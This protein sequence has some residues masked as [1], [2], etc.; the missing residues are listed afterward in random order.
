MS[1]NKGRRNIS[2][3]T[4]ARLSIY[5]RTLTELQ[6]AGTV[7]LYSHDLAKM[8]GGTAAQ[9][10]RDLMAV[11]YSGSPN[12]GYSVDDLLASVGSFIDGPVV[13]PVA[14][15]GVGNLGR[16]ILTFFTARRPMLRIVAAFDT[17]PQKVNRVINGCKVYHFD[18]LEEVVRKKNIKVG[19]ITVPGSEAQL[20]AN[21]LVAGGVRGV[22]N[23]APVPLRTP[24]NVYLD[25][26]DMTASLETVA[27]FAGKG[28]NQQEEEEA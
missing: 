12:K 14:L 26:L 18:N 21:K 5:R 20:V 3:K 1:N 23:L 11:G 16:A 27:Y 25:S 8:T 10:R 4:V 22:L 7:R 6:E 19:I 2:E 17:D 15:V 9:V 24:P 13:Q 28:N